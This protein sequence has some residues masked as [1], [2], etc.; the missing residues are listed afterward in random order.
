MK[1]NHVREK[2]QVGKPTI[3][4]FLG[5]GSPSV[6]E[7][8]AHAGF[9][10]L[11][12]ETEHNGL[13]SAEI[14]HMLRAI[15]GTD[16]VPLV[17]VP[18]S[19]HVYIQRALDMGAMGV[20]VPMVKTAGEAEKIVRATR[21][22]PDGARSWGPLRASHYTFD[23]EDYL[24]RANENILVVLIIETSEAVDN[25][26]AIAAVPGVDVLNLGPWDMSLSL[27]LDPQKLPLPEVDAILDR[28]LE[29][30]G[31]GVVAV[32]EGA[33]TPGEL[34]AAQEKGV[35]FLSYGGDYGLLA[36]A[37]REGLNAF[38]RES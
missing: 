19:S 38:V 4:C 26:E 13:D 20:V 3:G 9:D 12:I 30:A 29:A 33:G 18:S 27:G 17:R 28:M 37:A 1:T 23:T 21:L 36:R 2:L 14:E 22:P 25:L 8:M 5:L 35:T 6:A 31:R 32:G 10:W 7:L 16:T 15:D 11:V 24:R 34:R